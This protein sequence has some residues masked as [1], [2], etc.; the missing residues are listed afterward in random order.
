MCIAYIDD[1]DTENTGV[2]R[3]LSKKD[4]DCSAKEEKK[5]IVTHSHFSSQCHDRILYHDL[6]HGQYAGT[7][8]H[9]F[10]HHMHI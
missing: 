10:A 3:P 5:E 4:S 9:A 6:D 8:F 1:Y 2:E 7:E